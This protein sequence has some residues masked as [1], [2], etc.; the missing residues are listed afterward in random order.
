M[1]FLLFF[2]LSLL[3]SF[4][5]I[6]AWSYPLKE[7]SKPTAKCKFSYW[8]T[9]WSD[10]K[11][12]LP[13]LTPST[14]VK[15]KNDVNYYRRI[16]TIL[17]ASS[18]KYGWDVWNG[19]H[20]WTDFATSLWTPV[21]SIWPWRVVFAWPK[22][23]RWKV[24]VIQ[25]KINWK[26]IYSIYAHLNKIFV[27]FN[28][29]VREWEKIWEVWHSGNSY[30]NHLHFQID[31][32]QHIWTH[33]FWF[34]YCWKWQSIS[35]IVNSTTCLSEVEKYTVDPLAFLESQWAIIKKVEKQ[36]IS[37]PQVKID[38][39]N[40]VP[41]ET[42]Q[43]KITREFLATHKFS[44]KFK[45]AWVYYLGKYWSFDISLK[46]S[47]GR[48]YK[49]L[50]PEDLK[51]VYDKSFFYSFSPRGLKVINWTRKITFLPKKT[52]VTY[53]QVKL[54]NRIIYQKA[55]R[56]VKQWQYISPKYGVLFSL[57][58]KPYI[59]YPT[60]GISLFKD[61]KFVNIIKVPFSWRYTITATSDDVIFCKAPTNLKKLKFFK[62]NAY[63]SSKKI[64]FSYK[65]TLF[66]I[67]IFKFYSNSWKKTS[68]VLK[69]SKWKILAKTP[70]LSFKA[71]KL[72][73][74]KD[75][76]KI[77]VLRACKKWLCLNL[78]DKWY[79]WNNKNLTLLQLKYLVSNIL[80]YL[81]KNK[82]FPVY[83]T[84]RKK[85]ITR[86]QFVEFLLNTLWIQVKDYKGYKLKYIDVRNLSNED[87]NKIVYL[88]KL[89]FKW[90]DKF[91]KYHFQPHKNITLSE[92]LYLSNFLLDKL[93]K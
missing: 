21:Y 49:N 61:D 92:A 62:C 3:I 73:D 88:T 23:A 15:Y 89:W 43:E 7:V 38:R 63:N 70:L 72:V 17:W 19:T 36:K 31:T 41:Y 59:W 9:L 79:I 84:D 24:V 26:Y 22:W 48:N 8:N 29:I 87:Y 33:P 66:W 53:I 27:T 85:Y 37:R 55:I 34:K 54:W 81:W 56:I 82:V 30:W 75:I 46:D 2:I 86:I 93:K 12:P 76:Y 25:H 67:L 10:C 50:L 32:D 35:Q 14:Y 91:A 65:D 44:F 18:Y 5:H 47:K 57:S 13:K 45:N 64:D 68:L 71:I 74:N 6:F 11:I 80:T 39:K 16:Y 51:I 1:K 42:I 60:W 83:K 69:N 40:L 58:K 28:Q 78:V 4:S 52:G 77:D 90:K 20:L